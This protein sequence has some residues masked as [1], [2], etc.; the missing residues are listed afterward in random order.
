MKLV[1]ADMA[2]A[3]YLL[4]LRNDPATRENSRRTEEVAADSHLQW[5]AA[6]LADRARRLY[7]AY[8][9]FT[10]VGT[11]RLDRR[12]GEVELSLTVDPAH[13]GKGYARQIIAELVAHT[14]AGDRLTAEVWN[15]NDRCIKA[16]LHEGFVARSLRN[17]GR[18]WLWLER[19]S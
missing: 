7:I 2:D 11:G 3:R 13:R 10:R 5:L 8:D 18:V 16:F 4:A 15:E 14:N 19:T 12:H 17:D 1:L 6:S 9:G